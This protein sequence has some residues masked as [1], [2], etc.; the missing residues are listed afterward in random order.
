M[1][2]IVERGRGKAVAVATGKETEIGKIAKGILEKKE[3]KT[4]LQKNLKFSQKRSLF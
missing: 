1:G 2:S 4:P 3:E